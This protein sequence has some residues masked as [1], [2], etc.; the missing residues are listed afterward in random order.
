[1]NVMSGTAGTI[2]LRAVMLGQRLETRGL[3]REGT[4]ALMPLTLRI[5]EQGVAFLFRDGVVVL[6][7]LSAAEERALLDRL[8]PRLTEPL[9]TPEIEQLSVL[10]RPDGEDQ[11]EAS[12]AILLKDAS[13]DRLQIL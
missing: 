6:V 1:M 2:T 7:G 10:M 12:G 4:I 5:G 9:S 13:P 11:I 3:E 8:R